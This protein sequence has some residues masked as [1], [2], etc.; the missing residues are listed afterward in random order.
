MLP[1]LVPCLV[2]WVVEH[3][4]VET[5][6]LVHTTQVQNALHAGVEYPP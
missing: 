5:L 2:G 6:I 1:T 4:D 3:G